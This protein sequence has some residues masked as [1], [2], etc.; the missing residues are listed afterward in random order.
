VQKNHF[1]CYQSFF[2]SARSFVS[3]GL[4]GRTSAETGPS[5][6][7]YAGEGP[8]RHANVLDLCSREC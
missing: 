8:S 6:R 3:D 5:F 1:R 2:S 7:R 4:S